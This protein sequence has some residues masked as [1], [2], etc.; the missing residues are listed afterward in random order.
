VTGWNYFGV[1]ICIVVIFGIGVLTGA[2][3]AFRHRPAPIPAVV[4]GLPSNYWHITGNAGGQ[5]INLYVPLR[6]PDFKQKGHQ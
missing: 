2:T 3:Y 6:T 5:E 4:M 1:L